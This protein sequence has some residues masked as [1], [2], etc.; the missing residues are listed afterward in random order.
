MH[1]IAAQPART[2][3]LVATLGQPFAAVSST[4]GPRQ[5]F[6]KIASE[7][8]P[9]LRVSARIRH[10]TRETLATAR[11]VLRYWL[12]ILDK[13]R[14]QLSSL[15]PTSRSVVS[16]RHCSVGRSSTS[17]AQV[18]AHESLARSNTD[19]LHAFSSWKVP[20]LFDD[21]SA[22]RLGNPR[23]ASHRSSVRW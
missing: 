17:T 21:S 18:R 2:A 16:E 1:V 23:F 12:Q 3:E 13:V 22:R 6:L 9:A 7:K 10:A 8:S 15:T 4:P 11:A 14:S 19:S 20:R 5:K